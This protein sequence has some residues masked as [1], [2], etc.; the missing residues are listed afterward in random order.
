MSNEPQ[1]DLHYFV[2]GNT[3]NLITPQK[4]KFETFCIIASH[5]H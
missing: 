2:L 1:K 3:E 4:T 5:R